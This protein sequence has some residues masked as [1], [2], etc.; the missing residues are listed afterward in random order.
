MC[1]IEGSEH[2]FSEVI[3][4]IF[5]KYFLVIARHTRTEPIKF[6]RSKFIDDVTKNR[7]NLKKTPFIYMERT[8]KKS[9][10]CYFSINVF[11]I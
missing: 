10:L 4:S 11:T 6:E 7:Q 8:F 3:Q 1:L 5:M 2:I 9:Y